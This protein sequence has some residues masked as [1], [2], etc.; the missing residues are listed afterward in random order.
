MVVI[1]DSE[2]RENEGDIAVAAEFI[3]AEQ[4]NFMATHARGLICMTMAPEICDRLGLELMVP[5]NHSQY[6]TAFTVSI[7]AAEGVSTGIS[8]ADRA[9]TVRVAADPQA[10]PASLIQPGHIVPLRAKPNGVLERTGQTE[11]S[12]DMSRM[13]GLVP[14]AVICEIMNDDG[15]MAR[16]PDLE[17]F[18]QTHGLKMISITDMIEY[19]RRT[20]MHVE[21]VGD[22][23]LPTRTGDFQ[24]I[25]FRSLVD[26]KQHMALVKGDV[27]GAKDV[28]VRIHSE[29]RTGDIFGSRRCDCGEQLETALAEIE[30]SGCGVLVYLEQEGRG[31]GLLNKLRSYELQEDGLDTVEA[32]LQ[33]GFDDDLREYDVAAQILRDLGVNNVQMLTN[34]PRKIE[35][36]ERYGVTVAERV[37]LETTPH[38]GNRTYLRAKREK[39]GHLLEHHSLN[40]D[41]EP[42][43][44]AR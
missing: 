36:L 12:V 30:A 9:H 21:R 19:R 26:G 29:C 6:E 13:S 34:N 4:V 23:S 33:L 14:A 32:N 41:R 2:D 28:L 11:G 37:P 1:V 15:S 43:G 20:E 42:V 38:E 10:T 3:T 39:L 7:E 22:A 17:V 5:R 24:A 27:S 16:V 18:C 8:A 40:G 25:G 35:A 31:I 44:S